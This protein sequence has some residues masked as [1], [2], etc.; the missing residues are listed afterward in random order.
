MAWVIDNGHSAVGFSVRHMMLSNAR[1]NF[2][3]FSG[4]VD[5]NE[6]DPAS[7]S[8]DVSVDVASVDTKDEKRDGHLK[9]PDFFDTEKYPAL[10]FKSVKVEKTSDTT[11]KLHGN[12][13]IKDVTKP[14]VLDVEY[15]GQA[16]SPWGTTSAGFS[17]STKVNREDFGLVWNAPLETGG[18]LVGKDVKIEIEIEIVKQA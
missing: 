10:T 17:A 2:N 1:G 6:A 7:S 8:V 4:T 15:H 14:V 3:K 18:V 9:S 16:K 5:F 11:A 13:T 12:L